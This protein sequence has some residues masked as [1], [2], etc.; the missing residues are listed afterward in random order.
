M[1]Q[2]SFDIIISGAGMAG[3]S[4]CYRALT[5]GL[6]KKKSIALID[7][8]FAA[9]NDKTWCFWEKEAGPF[10]KIVFKNWKALSFFSNTGGQTILDNGDYKYKMLRSIDFKNLCLEFLKQ[11][12]NVHFIEDK[13]I[14]QQS[15]GN[16]AVFKSTSVQYTSQLGFNTIYQ[17]PTISPP[18]NYFL[19]HFKGWFIESTEAVFDKDSMHLM[20][21]RPSQKHGCTFM[22]VLPISS[23]KALVEYTLFTKT[24]LRDGEYNDALHEFIS[25]QLQIKNYRISESE[26]GVI[27]MT[28]YIFNRT[29]GNIINLG[30]AGG[31]TRASTGYTFQTTQKTIGKIIAHFKQNELGS[32]PKIAFNTKHHLLD[33]TILKVFEN[34]QYPPHEIFRDLFTK[35]SAQAIFQFL[36]GDTSILTDIKIMKS[37]RA[38]Y[39]IL[40]FIQSIKQHLQQRLR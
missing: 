10:E 25:T 17:T 33:S 20:D 40:P 27:P 9:S 12:E 30:S 34:N 37:L 32:M 23:K 22:Y 38:K 16:K 24:I 1:E 2:K 6:W 26:K 11:Q 28:D 19:Q 5:T 29:N 18:Q 7:I 31:D 35:T 4:L 13:I 8:N 14:E 15:T 39:F 3:L 21:F 36:D